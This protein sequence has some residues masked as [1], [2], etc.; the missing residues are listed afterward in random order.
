M[1][2]TNKYVWVFLEG[3][4]LKDREGSR[5][6]FKWLLDKFYFEAVKRIKM[7]Q[8]ISLIMEVGLDVK[9]SE[10]EGTWIIGAYESQLVLKPWTPPFIKPLLWAS[11]TAPITLWFTSPCA[12]EEKQR[13]KCVRHTQITFATKG[14]CAK[15]LLNHSV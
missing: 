8:V 3:G 14:V 10:S 7:A 2:E 13:W 11:D 12:P 9:N 5:V 15:G 6:V 4:H 1:G